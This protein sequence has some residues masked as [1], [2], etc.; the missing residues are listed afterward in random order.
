MRRSHHVPKRWLVKRRWRVVLE[1]TSY[2]RIYGQHQL[3]KCWCVFTGV[4]LSEKF[5][6][7]FICFLCVKMFKKS[8]LQY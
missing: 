3:G 6:I 8:K 1:V 2:T 7:F 5:A 4:S